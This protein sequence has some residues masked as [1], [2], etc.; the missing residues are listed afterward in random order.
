[1]I[2]ILYLESAICRTVPA[3][4]DMNPDPNQICLFSEDKKNQ[5]SR[6]SKSKD[7]VGH[8]CPTK[9]WKHDKDSKW[10]ICND[11]CAKQ[12]GKNGIFATK[13]ESY[14]HYIYH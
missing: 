5:F 1:M 8:W 13:P 9:G 2:L 4:S 10:G 11:M 14:D 12:K 6:C 3:R 7:D